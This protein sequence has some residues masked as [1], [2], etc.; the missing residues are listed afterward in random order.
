MPDASTPD[1]VACRLLK[2][3]SLLERRIDL[4]R[5]S[6]ALCDDARGF[7]SA[8][9]EGDVYEMEAAGLADVLAEV[10]RTLDELRE[11]GAMVPPKERW[12]ARQQMYRD[13]IAELIVHYDRLAVLWRTVDDL[14]V[15]GGPLDRHEFD[16]DAEDL[17]GV[18]AKIDRRRAALN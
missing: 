1:N 13:C 18:L 4:L 16:Q 6:I 17:R 12:A 14:D 7:F 5:Q 2:M 3:K 11:A 8:G 15:L 9:W 10:N